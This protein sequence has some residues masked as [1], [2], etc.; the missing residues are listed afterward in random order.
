MITLLDLEAVV[1][2]QI[3]HLQETSQAMFSYNLT[4]AK[5]LQAM[6]F[7][8]LFSHFEGLEPKIWKMCFLM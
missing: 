7:H 4:L 3:P 6:I 8:K 2:G 1:K 5:D